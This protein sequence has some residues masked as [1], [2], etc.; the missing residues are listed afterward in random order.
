MGPPQP[1]PSSLSR[2]GS[3]EAY[4]TYQY[5]GRLVVHPSTSQWGC[6]AAPPFQSW[7]HQHPCRWSTQQ[8]H[9]WASQ[10]TGGLPTPSLRWGGGIPRGSE[11]RSRTSVGHSAK[12][13]ALVDRVHQWGHLIADNPS[14]NHPRRLS[15]SSPSM[16]IDT[17]F[18][19][20]L[21]YRVPQQSSHW[22]QSDR[23]DHRP[24]IKPHFWNV[25]GI[26]HLQ[27]PLFN[28]QE[29][30]KPPDPG[31]ALQGY[32]KQPPPSPH[33]SSQA[34]MANVMAHSSHS[35]LHGTPGREPAILLSHCQP[36]PSTCWMMYCTS[37]RKWKMQLFIYSL[38]GPHNRHM[39][40]M[41]PIRNRSQSLPKWN[42]YFWG[43]Q[44]DK[45]LVCHHDWR[46]WGHLWDCLKEGRGCL[47]SFHQQ[48]GSHLSIR[49]QES[50][51]CQCSA[52]L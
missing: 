31:E 14:Q 15:R 52:S 45:D 4:C 18:L 23:G 28:G 11:W 44:R 29:G 12:A 17:S 16:V 41:G 38:P 2:G 42:W 22:S 9:L 48:S 33:G 7:T 32:L 24:L 36:T 26:L 5:K 50:Q 19:P 39:L 43:Y 46:C 34:D 27:F 30:G 40:P 25:R 13:T 20:A 51:S 21:H 47:S 37:K 10:P 6:T 3:E 1:I 35:L 8:K 49:D